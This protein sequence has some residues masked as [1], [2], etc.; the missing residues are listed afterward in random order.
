MEITH[1]ICFSDGES[2]VVDGFD[3]LTFYND[4]NDVGKSATGYH[5]Q[6][7]HGDL[8]NCLVENKLFSLQRANDNDE[9]SYRN[10]SFAFNNGTFS[11]NEP[12]IMT[13]NA[14]TTIV[15]FPG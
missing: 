14:V 15:K 11:Q 7:N 5:W 10:N 13:T 8:M 12:L 6:R 2:V 1:E 9:L 4:L 3:K